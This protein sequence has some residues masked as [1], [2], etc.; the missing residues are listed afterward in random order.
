MTY[1]LLIGANNVT[2]VVEYDVLQDTLDIVA[3]G[4][5]ITRTM[6]RWQGVNEESCIVTIGGTITG[7]VLAL[8]MALRKALQQDSIGYYASGDIAFL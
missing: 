8:V 1:N 5:T 4:Y 2:H 6:G 7:G 3:E